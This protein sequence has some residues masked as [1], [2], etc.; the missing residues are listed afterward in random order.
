MTC[1]RGRTRTGRSCRAWRGRVRAEAL[2][3]LQPVRVGPDRRAD[4][5]AQPAA[6]HV[7][8]YA[9][10][11]GRWLVTRDG[12]DFLVYYLP[13]YDFASHAPGPDD[14]DAALARVRRGG[15]RADRRGGWRRGVPRALRRHPLAD[16]GQTHVERASTR[17][18]GRSSPRHDAL[19]TASNRAGMV[20]ARRRAAAS[21]RARG[22]TGT[23]RPTSCS[24]SRAARPSC[25]ATARSSASRRRRLDDERRR[26]ARRLS[27]RARARLG[28][29]RESER[30][31]A[32]RLGGARWEFADL[33]G[34]HHAG[35]GSHG[36]LS[37]GDSVVPCSPSGSTR[38]PRPSS[39][40]RRPC[41]RT[42]ASSAAVRA[43]AVVP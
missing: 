1:Y 18:R 24:S 23:L 11:V 33:A 8:A 27:R 30:G 40:S 35:G 19:V 42:S 5:G 38:C 25:A 17:P 14:A 37:A 28:R 39:T 26:G 4:R 20:Y 29:A 6:R 32:A 12:F 3:L 7:D 9:A 21:A 43:R 15:R 34:R 31:R 13:D 2:L 22:S 41:S 10:A 16:H 36:S